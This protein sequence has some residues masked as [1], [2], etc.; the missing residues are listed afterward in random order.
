MFFRKFPDFMQMPEIGLA[1]ESGPSRTAVMIL[2]FSL[3]RRYPE[4]ASGIIYTGSGPLSSPD[5]RSAAIFDK[6]REKV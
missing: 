1:A 4:D 6:V 3:F 2:F 5:R